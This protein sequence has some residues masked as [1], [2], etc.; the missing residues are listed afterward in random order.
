MAGS[1]NEQCFAD[2]KSTL[3][4]VIVFATLFI[5]F[6]YAFRYAY[7]IVEVLNN[8]M[9]RHWQK[10][11]KKGQYVTLL[12]TMQYPLLVPFCSCS[13]V[14]TVSSKA[15]IPIPD[16]APEPASP[17]KW[18]EPML[19]A[20]RD[21]PTWGKKEN[22]YKIGFGGKK[23]ILVKSEKR[24]LIATCYANAQFIVDPRKFFKLRC[25]YAWIKGKPNNSLP[26]F[27]GTMFEMGL[28]GMK[29]MLLEERK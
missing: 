7:R 15:A 22:G 12:N 29:C 13:C 8:T 19:L 20:K 25:F 2:W 18:P 27:P 1:A 4:L 17:I 5:A 21:A 28:T 6:H 24:Y 14:L 23:H 11:N 10:W 3:V 9:V 26:N 16:A